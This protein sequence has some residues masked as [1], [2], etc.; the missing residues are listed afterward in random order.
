MATRDR[1]DESFLARWSRLK[2][3]GGALPEQ[4][5][6]AA[7]EA[8]EEARAA[9]SPAPAAESRDEPAR[10]G[11]RVAAP[12]IELP[13]PDTLDAT[14]DFRIFLREGVPEDLQRR[15]LRRLWRVN[16]IISSVC[17]LVEY[18]E[19][20]TDAA[21]VIP[22]LKSVFKLGLDALDRLAEADA[23]TSAAEV[24]PRPAAGTGDTPTAEAAKDERKA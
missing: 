9:P 24:W 16:P 15:A 8:G 4:G 13:D 12:E 7:A 22:G 5:S 3:A 14:A 1:E 11:E 23:R 18:G 21:T 20:Y 19:D 6:A 2:R 10:S 17:P